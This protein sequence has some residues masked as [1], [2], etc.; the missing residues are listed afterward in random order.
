MIWNTAKFIGI[1]LFMAFLIGGFGLLMV[2][3]GLTFIYFVGSQLTGPVLE[4]A[5]NKAQI[6]QD[7]GLNYSANITGAIQYEKEYHSELWG[8]YQ[9]TSTVWML[10]GFLTF[11]AAA[12]FYTGWTEVKKGG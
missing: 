4:E 5:G 8:S 3:P 9:N 7:Q 11:I 10:M 2:K 1:T 6:L 12:L